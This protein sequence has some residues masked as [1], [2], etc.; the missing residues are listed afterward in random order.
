M[1][2]AVRGRLLRRQHLALQ[3]RRLPRPP[4]AALLYAAP[5]GPTASPTGPRPL[6]R[7][8]AAPSEPGPP[9]LPQVGGGGEGCPTHVRRPTQ[10]WGRAS[11]WDD[12]IGA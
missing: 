1:G 2:E 4:A 6:P 9:R 7:E 12:V 10:A 11:A 5:P 8:A 3:P